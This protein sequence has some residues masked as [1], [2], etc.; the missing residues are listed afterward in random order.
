MSR[1]PG[2]CPLSLSKELDSVSSQTERL[3]RNA[4]TANGQKATKS[5]WILDLVESSFMSHCLIKTLAT[6]AVT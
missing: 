5:Q 4:E 1:D 3:L 6:N 2:P